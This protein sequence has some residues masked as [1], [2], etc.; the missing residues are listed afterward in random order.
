MLTASAKNRFSRGE[1]KLADAVKAFGFD[2]RGKTV[3]DIGSSTGG[4]TEVALEGGAERVIA[5]EK[6]TNQM[7]APMRYDPR[8]ELHEK[9]DIFDTER[10]DL[11]SSGALKGASPS[12]TPSENKSLA[13][14]HIVVLADVSFVSLRPI[15]VKAKELVNGQ[16]EFLVMLKPQFEAKPEQLVKG[17]VKNEKI[18]REI[19]KEFEKWLV[20]NNF[21]ILKKRDNQLAGKNGN[22]ERF[23]LLKLTK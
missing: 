2:F 10:K 15:L 11:F 4:F 9:T 19:I 12:L 22:K 5:V 13:P 18:R 20:K 17:V 3:L 21:V 1:V 16:E 14:S 6:G 23:Y 8:I 7:K